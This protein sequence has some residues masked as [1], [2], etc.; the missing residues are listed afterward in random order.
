MKTKSP[1]FQ[2]Y[3]QDFT[4]GT[5]EFN[6]EEVGAYLRLLIYQWDKL[7]LPDDDK[8]LAKIAGCKEK[9]IK[10]VRHKFL[11][12]DDGLIRNVRLETEREKQTAWKEKSSKA[13][14]KSA[15]AKCNQ[16]ST[17]PQPNL[18]QGSNQNSTN[19]QPNVN[20]SSSSSKKN[21]KEKSKKEKFEKP[22]K[23]EAV[24][25]L[26]H[27]KNLDEFTAE[28]FADAWMDHFESNGW[29]VGG[30]SP[31]LDWKASIRNWMRN[32]Q[33]FNPS[34]NGQQTERKPKPHDPS[35]TW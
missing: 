15:Q 32:D 10:S 1:A 9:V 7:G 31:M 12:C 35:N 29:R 3:Y 23:D 26:V 16:T 17:K 4:F 22:T 33:K 5:S 8:K 27:E 2:F 24:A 30:R 18:N 6:C 11:P 20:S 34:T 14:E 25:Y 21:T 19:G 28:G 13:G